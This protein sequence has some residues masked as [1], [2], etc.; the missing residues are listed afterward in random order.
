VPGASAARAAARA[1]ARAIAVAL[2]ASA[3]GAP[4]WA[5]PAEGQ[6]FA[7][8]A[9]AEAEVAY[10]WEPESPKVGRFVGLEVVSCRAPVSDPVDEIAVD[11]TMPAHGHGMNYRPKAERVA[12]GHFKVTGLMLHMPGRWRLTIDL[13]QGN[14]R[15][16]LAHEL[17]LAP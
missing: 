8:L 11:A 7:R 14:R 15:T 5:C 2:A 10:R 9:S 3:I 16:R 12:A 13:Y 17:T 6:G 4:A 1:L